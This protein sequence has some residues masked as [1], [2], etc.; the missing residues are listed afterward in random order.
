MPEA[1]LG[2]MHFPLNCSVDLH[3]N[4]IHTAM[5][6]HSENAMVAS[7]PSFAGIYFTVNYGAQPLACERGLV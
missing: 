7:Q 6:S 2:A 4:Y 1:D 3:E 5:L